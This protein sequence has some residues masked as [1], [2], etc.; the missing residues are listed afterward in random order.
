M[1][2]SFCAACGTTNDLQSHHLVTRREGGTNSEKNLLTLY[3]P[4]NAKPH[5]RP[6]WRPA[7]ALRRWRLTLLAFHFSTNQH[8]N[9]ISHAAR[10]LFPVSF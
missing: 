7:F 4:Y 9:F 6:L 8:G 3:H 5:K 10:V 2:L 1:R